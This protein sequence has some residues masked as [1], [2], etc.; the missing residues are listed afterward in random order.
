MFFLDALRL[1]CFP[2][3]FFLKANSVQTVHK[4]LAKLLRKQLQK[5]FNDQTNNQIGNALP[6]D[7]FS[8]IKVTSKKQK[9]RGKDFVNEPWAQV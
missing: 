5:D 3:G 4:K 2:L 9:L 1:Y 8:I 6:F 7:A